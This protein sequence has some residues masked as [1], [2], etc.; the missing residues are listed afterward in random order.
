MAGHRTSR[1]G[2]QA[3]AYGVRSRRQGYAATAG[4]CGAPGGNVPE[5]SLIL[6]A[7]RRKALFSSLFH[8]LDQRREHPRVVRR[9]RE[10]AVWTIRMER[11][12]FA[13]Q[14]RRTQQCLVLDVTM[15]CARVRPA[16]VRSNEALSGGPPRAPKILPGTAISVAFGK[17]NLRARVFCGVELKDHPLRIRNAWIRHRVQ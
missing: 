2:Q 7:L 12:S 16:F 1:R 14:A 10:E 5:G 4:I 9:L 6:L 8:N 17:Q 15:L 3:L 13:C 11:S